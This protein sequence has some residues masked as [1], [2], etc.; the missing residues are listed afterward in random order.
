MNGNMRELIQSQRGLICGRVGH[1]LKIVLPVEKDDSTRK[2]KC[3]CS[4]C[5][6][7][8][9][10]E[11]PEAGYKRFLADFTAGKIV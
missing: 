9:W 2:V 11:L 1:N 6:Q 8:F 4:T 5:E 3:I 7:V 10:D